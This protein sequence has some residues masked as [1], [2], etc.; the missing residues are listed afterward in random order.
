MVKLNIE[1]MMCRNGELKKCKDR[2]KIV[3]GWTHFYII[4][5]P[6]SL[7]F[8]VDFS[9]FGSSQTVLFFNGKTAFFYPVS[10]LEIPDIN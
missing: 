5:K 6:L 8:P 3:K 10:L 7:Y 1:V 9:F 4:V 2:S